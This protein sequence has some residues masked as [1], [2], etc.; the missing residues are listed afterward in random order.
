[1]KR[2]NGELVYSSGILILDPT[3]RFGSSAAGKRE[4]FLCTSIV[5]RKGNEIE[6]FIFTCRG[7]GHTRVVIG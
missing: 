1:M 6:F 4:Y 2:E 7:L 5:V 3:Q